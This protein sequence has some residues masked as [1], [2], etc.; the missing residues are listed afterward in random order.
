MCRDVHSESAVNFHLER[1][2]G[3]GRNLVLDPEPVNVCVIYVLS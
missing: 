2:P 1:T 3:H